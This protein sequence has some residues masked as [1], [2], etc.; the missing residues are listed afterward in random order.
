MMGNETLIPNTSMVSGY[1]FTSSAVQASL[2][3]KSI[4]LSA[5]S[6]NAGARKRPLNRANIDTLKD[7]IKTTGLLQPIGVVRGDMTKGEAPYTLV[8]GFHRFTA[9]VEL[10]AEAQARG[11]PPWPVHYPI[12]RE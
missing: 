3:I 8:W 9:M 2:E 1:D 10:S 4:M 5:I 7:A 12:R 11:G 6:T